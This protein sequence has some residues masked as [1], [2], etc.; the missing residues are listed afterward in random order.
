MHIFITGTSTGI[1]HA[2]ALEFDQNLGGVL[3]FSLVSRKKNLLD[4]LAARLTNKSSVYPADLSDDKSAA[5]TLKKAIEENGP[6]DILINNAGVQNINHFTAINDEEAQKLF[7]LNYT[8]PARL[9]RQ[10]LPKMAERNSGAIINIA[11][12]GAITPTPF[13]AEYC[14][15]KAALGAL[16]TALQGEYKDTAIHFLGVYPGPVKTAMAD[17]A[18]DRYEGN[19]AQNIPYGTPE[20]LAR[21][22]LKAYKNQTK[23]IVYPAFYQVA[24]F[25]PGLST[26]VTAQLAPEPKEDSL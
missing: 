19:T 6:V 4:G 21:E 24:D 25:F 23:K 18:N 17:L 12:L 5:D 13:M 8:T 26:W 20:G 16:T 1:G 14:A 10:V 9:M 2:I 3:N 22:I 15:S 7:R 11:S